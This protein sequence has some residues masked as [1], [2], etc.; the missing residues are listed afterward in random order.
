MGVRSSTD[1]WGAVAKIL[2]WAMAIGILTM[3]GCGVAMHWFL[4]GDIGLKFAVYQ[5]HKSLGFTML[6]LAGMR[7]AWR[8]AARETPR[9]LDGITPAQRRLAEAVHIGLY[10]CLV[11]QPLIG[12][13]LA[14]ASPLNIPTIVF[15]LFTLPRLVPGDPVL[16]SRFA[17]AHSLVGWTL[18]GLLT[19]HLAGAVWHHFVLRDDTLRRM[20]PRMRRATTRTTD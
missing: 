11:A 14:S 3:I 10:G 20:A 4:D 5:F 19:L 7:L 12:W 15:G 2:H 17:V 8:L 6:C 18:V 9:P 1:D 16:E 13:L